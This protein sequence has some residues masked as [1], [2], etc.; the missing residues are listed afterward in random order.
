MKIYFDTFIP[1][2]EVVNG[3]IKISTQT[4]RYEIDPEDV[5]F[6]NEQLAGENLEAEYDA[7]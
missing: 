6:I 3:V 7:Q 4:I 2:I 1:I 5:P